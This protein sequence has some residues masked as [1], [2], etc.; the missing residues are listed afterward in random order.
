MD[1]RGPKIE[2]DG[3]R[4]IV[5]VAVHPSVDDGR[6]PVKR[7]LGDRLEI[8]AD[9]LIDGH[10]KIAA[11][12]HLRSPRGVKLATRNEKDQLAFGIVGHHEKPST[13][14]ADFTDSV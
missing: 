6:F 5:I 4:R 8:A 3:R 13:D 7:T 14:F 2:A 9:L 12:A 1:P 10:D 11:V